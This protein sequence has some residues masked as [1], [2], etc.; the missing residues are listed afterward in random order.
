VPALVLQ[1]PELGLLHVRLQTWLPYTIMVCLN[2]REY[3]AK[4][5]GPRWQ[6]TRPFQQ[7]HDTPRHKVSEAS[8]DLSHQWFAQAECQHGSCTDSNGHKDQLDGSGH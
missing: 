6:P 2:G 3:L 8:C 4:Q 1:H 5:L 7:D